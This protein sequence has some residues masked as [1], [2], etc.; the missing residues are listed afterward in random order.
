MADRLGGGV[1]P[2]PVR[3]H[4]QST[5]TLLEEAS[6]PTVI[7]RVVR[8]HGETL[9]LDM[10]EKWETTIRGTEQMKENIRAEDDGLEHAEWQYISQFS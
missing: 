7:S 5:A 2:P 4:L 3:C 6:A 1:L 9:Y 8:A 10:H